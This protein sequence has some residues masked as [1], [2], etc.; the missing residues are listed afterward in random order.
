MALEKLP[1]AFSLGTDTF[2]QVGEKPEKELVDVETWYLLKDLIVHLDEQRGN[3]RP[4]NG[5]LHPWLIDDGRLL[6]CPDHLKQYR[7]RPES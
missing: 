6:C 2:L 7:T 4:K 5:G 3:T 1:E